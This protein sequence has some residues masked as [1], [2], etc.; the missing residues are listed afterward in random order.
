MSVVNLWHG[1]IS[2]TGF[3]VNAKVTGTSARL[4]VS[5]A[6]DLSAPVYFGPQT[7]TTQGVIDLTATGLANDTQHYYAIEDDGVLDL[8]LTG[9]CLTDPPPGTPLSFRV[10]AGACAGHG[11][12]GINSGTYY[13]PEDGTVTLVSNHPVFGHIAD[14]SPRRF[15]HLG[16]AHYYDEGT[17]NLDRF[18]AAYDHILSAPHQ[19]RLYSEAGIVYP[20]DDHDYGANN[21]RG[22][23]ASRP[24]A[25][26]A[27][28]ERVPSY[29]LPDGAGGG[30]WHTFV[31]GRV[32]FIVS[33]T[34]SY[35]ESGAVPVE[36][37]SILGAAQK[38]WFKDVLA[39]ATEPLICWVNPT[40]WLGALSA[41]DRWE[42]YKGERD[43]LG[44]YIEGL[45]LSDPASPQR[46]FSINGDSHMLAIDDGSNNNGTNGAGGFP[47]YHFASL[48][49]RPS[50]SSGIHSHGMK[51]DIQ[52]PWAGRGQ[53]GTLDV[54]DDGDTISVTATGWMYDQVWKSHTITISSEPDVPEVPEA[55]APVRLAPIQAG[56]G[57]VRVG[58]PGGALARQAKA[59]VAT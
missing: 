58:L 45:G 39:A 30:I 54:T 52:T 29:A 37:R 14:L 49:S 11:I 13:W 47:V 15:I 31:L 59:Y 23:S 22:D 26:T 21:S 2:D 56:L 42:G 34:R 9:K 48:D 8:S 24:A 17:N 19:A 44:A 38:Q 10:A 28:R 7:P 27:Y 53:Y 36:T 25:T 18:R 51:G 6:P 35:R 32:R 46:L 5:T 55:P 41:S 20:W 57:E 12:D 4:V 43:E 33:D 40:P 3:R 16:D 1:A 50:V